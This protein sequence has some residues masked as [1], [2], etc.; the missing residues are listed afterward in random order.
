MAS[1][2]CSMRACSAARSEGS[3]L[4]VRYWLASSSGLRCAQQ[5]RGH[6]L[7]GQA[8]DFQRALDPLAVVGASRAA[9]MGSSVA[10]SACS[11]GQPSRRRALPVR[12][13]APGRPAAGRPARRA[14]PVHHGAAGQQR[15]AAA[16]ADLVD[17][18]QRVGAEFGR[19]VRLRGVQ[20]VQQMLRH[21]RLLGG[22]GFGGADVH[23]SVDR[24]R[25]DVDDLHR[26]A[27]C[28]RQRGRAL[29]GRGRAGQTDDRRQAGCGRRRQGYCP[30]RKS[31]SRSDTD[32]CTQV[33]RPWLH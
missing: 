11:A 30:R 12:R 13:V 4:I 23:A 22:R 20:D 3:R 17:Q 33:G 29:A 5:Q 28:Q 15:H 9:V 25:I 8:A 19:R 14:A 18:A 2:R 31:L 32:H 7:A 26:P 1:K 24:G 10:S 21:A 6:G 16:R 27:F